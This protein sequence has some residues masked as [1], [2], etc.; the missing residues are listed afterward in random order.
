[1]AVKGA[2]VVAQ[3]QSK[4]GAAY[5]FGDE[6]PNTFDCS[7]L[8]QW[9]YKQLGIALPRTTYEQVKVGAEVPIANI[10]PGDLVFSTWKSSDPNGHVGMY[11]GNNQI[12]NAP[13]AGAVVRYQTL[14]DSYR[15]HITHIRRVPGVEGGPAAGMPSAAAANGGVS[16]PGWIPN[17]GDAVGALN[18]LSAAAG[19]LAES[20]QAIPRVADLITKAMLPSNILRGVMF[21]FGTMM[22][23]TGIWRISKEVR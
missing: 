12:I 23:I 3:A 20:A 1:M 6:G 13:H 10:Q 5:V 19:S 15:T 4:L 18:N 9:A 16:L 8:M 22:V 21:I 17:P 14:S 7:G 2:D 11:V